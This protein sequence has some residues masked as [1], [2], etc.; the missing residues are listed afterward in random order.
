MRRVLALIA[1]VALVGA[2]LAVP[3]FGDTEGTV[4]ATVTA[5]V[6]AISNSTSTVAYGIVDL[7]SADNLPT[8]ATF[9]A[10]NDGNVDAN[11]GIKGANTANWIL[12]GTT[13]ATDE[14]RHEASPDAF[15]TTIVLTTD[16]QS[17]ATSVTPTNST[18]VS[19]RLDAPAS[20]AFDTEQFAQVI[21]LATAS[22]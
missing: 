13:P 19:L 10:T 20:T 2:A 9:T 1:V 11:F 17:L 8:P 16:S 21:I 12:V 5:G 18:T 3:A 22:P 14:Y 4:T 7:G 6:V 15:T